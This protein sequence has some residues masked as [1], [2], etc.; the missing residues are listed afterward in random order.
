MSSPQDAPSVWAGAHPVP[1]REELLHK[2][3]ELREEIGQ[4]QDAVVSHAVVDQAIGVVIAV[5]GLRP[6]QGFEV[7]R[8]VSQNT[9]IKLRQ[10]A[11][12]IVDWV[13]TDRLPDEIR[14]ALDRALA[15]ARSA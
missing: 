3:G 9:N 11:E 14:E 2:I 7:L 6:D 15:A 8:D 4:L 13:H 12:R 5:G 10:I 1:G